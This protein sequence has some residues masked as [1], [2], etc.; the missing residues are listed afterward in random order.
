MGGRGCQRIGIDEQQ[1]GIGAQYRTPSPKWAQSRPPITTAP[2][3]RRTTSYH[4]VERG[5]LRT[6]APPVA[7]DPGGAREQAVYDAP[8]PLNRGAYRARMRFPRA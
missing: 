3:V 4:K 5:R 2:S 1:R 7:K 8:G 6:K